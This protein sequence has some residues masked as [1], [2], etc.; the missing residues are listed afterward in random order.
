MSKSG[1]SREPSSVE[2]AVNDIFCNVKPGFMKP[3]NDPVMT[4]PALVPAAVVTVIGSTLCLV[5]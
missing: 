3:A 1:V 2:D 5:C 4:T